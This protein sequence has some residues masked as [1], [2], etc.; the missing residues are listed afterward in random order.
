M[1]KSNPQEINKYDQ[2]YVMVRTQIIAEFNS[3]CSGYLDNG[4]EMK[5]MPEYTSGYH[6]QLFLKK[7][8]TTITKS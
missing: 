2:S 4:Y 5:G 7:P 8:K 6:K 3:E 1:K